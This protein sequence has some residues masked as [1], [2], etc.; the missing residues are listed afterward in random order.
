M[1]APRIDQINVVVSD[2]VGA[3]RFLQGLGIEMPSTPAPWDAHHLDV[4][5]VTTS[6]HGGH[7]LA[8]PRFG[9]DLDS[10]AFAQLWG[11]LDPSFTG[12][13]LNIRVDERGE[14]DE[15]HSRAVSLGGM[16]R[17]AP[18]DAF[19]GSRFALVE[20]PGPLFLGLMSVPS[21]AHRSA[22]PDPATFA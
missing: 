6:L 13:V 14:V 15:L 9:I 3:A 5:A 18:Y 20:G 1:V 12:L 11:G 22:P 4:P 8:E 7:D 2:V 10:S 19:W 21:P 16:S 17:K